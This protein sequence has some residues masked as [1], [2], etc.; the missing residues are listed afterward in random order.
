MMSKREETFLNMALDY[1]KQYKE[2]AWWKFKKRIELYKSY[3]SAFE[4]FIRYTK[5]KPK[6]RI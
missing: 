5:D 6:Q 4:L 2:C 1:K 3:Q